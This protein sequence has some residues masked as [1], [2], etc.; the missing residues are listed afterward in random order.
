[1]STFREKLHQGSIL[2]SDGAMGTLLHQRGIGLDECFDLLNLTQPALVAAIHRE[3]IEAGSNIIQ[4][5]TFGANH[6]KLHR[7]GQADRLVEIN[8]AGVD[9]VRRVAN[10]AF[11]DVLVAGDVGPLGMPLAPFGRLQPDEAREAFREQI[12]AL[13]DAGIDL[14]IIETITDLYELKEA[15]QAAREI[16]PALPVI[17][18]MTFTRDNVT[19]LGDSPRK[20]ATELSKL[21]VDVIGVNCS[22]GPNQILR[23]L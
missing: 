18:S 17:A 13:S 12:Q 16:N 1:M 14:L 15:V 23:V 20:V 10:A 21:G 19:T 4:T 6:F 11:K 5:N 3:Y 2:L 7:F 22:S 9:L 8:R